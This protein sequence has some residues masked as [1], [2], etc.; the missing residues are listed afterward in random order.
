MQGTPSARFNQG[1]LEAANNV[2][3]DT[4]EQSNFSSSP[5]TLVMLEVVED[6]LQ[7]ITKGLFV[8]I[9]DA[10]KSQLRDVIIR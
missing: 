10:P 9:V 6:L 5:P 4:R 3:E 1:P 8:D 2:E 7:R